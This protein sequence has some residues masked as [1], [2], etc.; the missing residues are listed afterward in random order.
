M[1]T[2]NTWIK[3]KLCAAICRTGRHL[4]SGSSSFFT[5][6][7]PL[8]HGLGSATMASFYFFDPTQCFLA[9][10]LMDLLCCGSGPQY[11]EMI[12][13][14]FLCVISLSS[15]LS[16]LQEGLPQLLPTATNYYHETLSLWCSLVLS[17]FW[18]WLLKNPFTYL[19]HLFVCYVFTA[20]WNESLLWPDPLSDWLIALSNGLMSQ[21]F[22]FLFVS[23]ILLSCSLCFDYKL[24]KDRGDVF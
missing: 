9:L 21:S 23:C 24:H 8:L 19:S 20:T 16:L 14:L 5:P 22:I 12:T 1:A 10:K 2:P 13:L 11:L 4:A 7:P 15:H 6:P 18:N 3:S 17:S